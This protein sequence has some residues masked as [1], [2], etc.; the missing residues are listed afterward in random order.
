[1]AR[2]WPGRPSPLGAT[3]DGIGTNFA[4]FSEVA[5]RIDLCLFEDDGTETCVPF[6]EVTGHVWHGYLPDVGPGTRYG[7]RVYGPYGGAH[8]C[9]PAKLLID[10]YAKALDGRIEW[11]QALFSYPFGAPDGIDKTDSAPSMPKSVVSNP[12]FDWEGDVLLHTPWNDTVIY[13]VHVKGAT[14]RH[15][16][17]EP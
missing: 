11:G 4:V 2:I 14:M 13:E 9:N 5:E 6:F 7:F 16:D 10:P 12:Y 17:I 3:F 1:M 8:R 15:P